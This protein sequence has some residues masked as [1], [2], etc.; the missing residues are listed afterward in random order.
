[1]ALNVIYR[2]LSCEGNLEK[3]TENTPPRF[4]VD[5]QPQETLTKTLR[6]LAETRGELRERLQ[7][8][9][10]ARAAAAEAEQKCRDAE[11]KCRDAIMVRRSKEKELTAALLRIDAYEE[12]LERTSS[13]FALER[14]QH[15]RD[16]EAS[17]IAQAAAQESHLVAAIIAQ[18]TLGGALRASLKRFARQSLT[19]SP[20]RGA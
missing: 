6:A 1:M 13:A 15:H 11:Q 18:A 7:E 10:A 9:D 14:R 4:F 16:M 12:S 19:P 5:H 3:D 8:A 17:R 2:A 20:M